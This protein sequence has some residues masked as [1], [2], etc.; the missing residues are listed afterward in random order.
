MITKITTWARTILVICLIILV[1]KIIVDTFWLAYS[2]PTEEAPPTDAFFRVKSI[3]QSASNESLTASEI[4]RW[5]FF[6]QYVEKSEA[7]KAEEKE[8]QEETIKDAPDTKLKL[9]LVGVFSHQDKQQAVAFIKEKGKDVKLFKIDDEITGGAKLVEVLPDR[10]ILQRSGKHEALRIKTSELDDKAFVQSSDEDESKKDSQAKRRSKKKPRQ[11]KAKAEAGDGMAGF[12]PG[13]TPEEK[14]KTVIKELDLEPVKED[15]SEGYVIGE[16][17]PAALL[18]SVG[19]KA[20]DKIVSVNGQNLG[21]EQQDV[22]VL[23]DVLVSGTATIEV[24]RGT[25]RFT[26]NYPP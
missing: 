22:A 3:D 26:V 19:L 21:E 24:V 4:N 9:E 6:G 12:I 8:A 13:D 23:N 2:G 14:R 18:G 25:R 20:G 17:A 10:V 11:Q 16:S 7:E 1:A 5:H 15:S